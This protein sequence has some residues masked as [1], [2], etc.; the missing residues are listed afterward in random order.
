MVE[1]G[2]YTA[3]NLNDTSFTNV[4]NFVSQYSVYTNLAAIA[5]SVDRDVGL[6]SNGQVVVWGLTNEGAK[7]V[8]ANL[9][10]VTAIAAGRAFNLALSNGV[11]I[12]WGDDTFGQCD[13]SARATKRR[14]DSGGAAGRIGY[15]G[16]MAR[17]WL[18]EI[19]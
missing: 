6:T 14:G 16:R 13:V 17:W 1:W 2:S 3:D 8:P 7:F 12:A 4:T 15:S 11:I 19:N 9:T 5:A 10:N 18:G